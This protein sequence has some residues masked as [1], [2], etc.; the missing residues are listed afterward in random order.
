[1]GSGRSPLIPLKLTI[2]ADVTMN[3]YGEK[4]TPYSGKPSEQFAHFFFPFNILN[5]TI[6]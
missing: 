5:Y 3:E 2:L 1:M 6:I 4:N